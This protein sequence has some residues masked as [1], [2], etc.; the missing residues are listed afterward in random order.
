M[1]AETVTTLSFTVLLAFVAIGLLVVTLMFF[2]R[3][4]LRDRS[5]RMRQTAQGF[6]QPGRHDPPPLPGRDRGRGQNRERWDGSRRN[7]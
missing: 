4:S 1:L 7:S 3:E 2:L 6:F 5:K